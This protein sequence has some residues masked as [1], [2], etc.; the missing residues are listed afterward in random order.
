[1]VNRHGI[2]AIVTLARG[3]GQQ[4]VAEGVETETTPQTIRELGVDY[5]QGS[6]SPNPPPPTTLGLTPITESPVSSRPSATA[7][8]RSKP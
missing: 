6:T 8:R 7:A 3:T 4:T 1:M 2:K 5:A